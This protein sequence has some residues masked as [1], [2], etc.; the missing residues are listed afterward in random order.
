MIIELCF[1]SRQL[2]ENILIGGSKKGRSAN[3]VKKAAILAAKIRN[4]ICIYI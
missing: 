4:P 2:S 1:V 3:I